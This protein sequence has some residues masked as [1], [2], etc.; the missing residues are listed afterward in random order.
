MVLVKK[1]REKKEQR[2]SIKEREEDRPDLVCF[3]VGKVHSFARLKGRRVLS[4]SK[5]KRRE[6]RNQRIEEVLACHFGF[7]TTRGSISFAFLSIV[8]FTFS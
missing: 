8:F 6:C 1:M 7:V 5:R 3:L 2:F 4:S